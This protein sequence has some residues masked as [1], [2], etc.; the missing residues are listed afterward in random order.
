VV[1]RECRKALDARR[2]LAVEAPFRRHD[3]QYRWML[4]KGTPRFRED[5]SFAGYVGCLIDIT[6]YRRTHEVNAC[7]AVRCPCG[8]LCPLAGGERTTAT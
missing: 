7:G 8:R 6:G 3:G 2:P 4:G 5:D 1:L